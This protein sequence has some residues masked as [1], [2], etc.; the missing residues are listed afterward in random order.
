[1]AYLKGMKQVSPAK[2]SL[3][4][5]KEDRDVLAGLT[6]FTPFRYATSSLLGEAAIRTYD[7]RIYY[8]IEPAL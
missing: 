7:K 8:S 6:C 1:M 4:F 3:S 5:K 2:P